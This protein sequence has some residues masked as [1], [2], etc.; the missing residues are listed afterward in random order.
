V[1]GHATLVGAFAG[2]MRGFFGTDIVTFTAGTED[3]NL[4][5]GVTR[6]FNSFTEAAIEDA[7]SRVYNGVH[8]DFDGRE[9]RLAGTAVGKYI[10]DHVLTPIGA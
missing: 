9:G 7:R 8:F 10:Y 2:V 6:T 1:S 3:P 5:S 4:P